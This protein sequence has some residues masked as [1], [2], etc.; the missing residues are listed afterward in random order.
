MVRVVSSPG[1]QA[2]KSCLFYDCS[3]L[4][5][6]RGSRNTSLSEMEDLQGGILDEMH[7]IRQDSFPPSSESE[8]GLKDFYHWQCVLNGKGLMCILL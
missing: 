7:L 3:L 6:C 2:C 1:S 8:N 4:S 5:P